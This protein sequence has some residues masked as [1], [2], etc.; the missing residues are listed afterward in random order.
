M[1]L[2]KSSNSV[3]Q[4]KV[5]VESNKHYCLQWYKFFLVLLTFYQLL[6]EHP[7]KSVTFMFSPATYLYFL[8]ESLTSVEKNIHSMFY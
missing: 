6:R 5:F 7:D 4:C 2:Y 3:T 1:F 8:P